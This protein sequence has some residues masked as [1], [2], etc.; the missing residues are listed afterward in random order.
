[1]YLYSA[2]LMMFNSLPS[3]NFL[4]KFKAFSDNKLN[5]AKIMISVFD[6][7]EKGENAGY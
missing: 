1:M 2:M 5:V 4:T 3:D 6:S 7:V